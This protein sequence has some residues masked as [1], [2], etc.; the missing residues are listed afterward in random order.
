MESL[1]LAC[2]RYLAFFVYERPK[3]LVLM[4]YLALLKQRLQCLNSSLLI[5]TACYKQ[6]QSN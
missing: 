2:V 6:V 4:I 3:V 1:R 5:L